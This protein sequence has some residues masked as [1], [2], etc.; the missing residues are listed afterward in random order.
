MLRNFARRAHRD[1]QIRQAREQ[2][3]SPQAESAL[4][5]ASGPPSA[6]TLL[7]AA[8]LQRLLA[9]L[10]LALDE[11]Y[12]STILV[13]FYQGIEPAEIARTSGVPAGTVRWRVSEGIRRLRAA[14][15]SRPDTRDWR[16]ALLPF[17]PG[18]GAGAPVTSALKG[19]LMIMSTK[20]KLGVVTFAVAALAIGAWTWSA[21][22]IGTRS[23]AG[24]GGS[25]E[26][27]PGQGTPGPGST[28]AETQAVAT[29]S[30]VPPPAGGQRPGALA[31][32]RPTRR[33]PPRLMA[34]AA[35]TA[36]APDPAPAERRGTLDKDE[37]R[38]AMRQVIPALKQCYAKLLE[39]QPQTSGRLM[40]QITI[41]ENGSGG[42]RISE[43]SVVPQSTDDGT[44]ELIAPLAEQCMLNAIAEAPFPAPQG[45]PVVVRYP[46]SFAPSGDMV[47]GTA[48]AP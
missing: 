12:R 22:P 25:P 39:Q 11:P 33:P 4:A 24:P 19:G 35:G 43:A 32:A 28:I 38:K 23:A 37:I 29:S 30:P 17:V 41:T 27:L 45:G 7:E 21:L 40:F 18:L 9:D 3:N 1:R 34:V 47:P 15:D 13:R 16:R 6:E 26:S 5:S 10:V 14:L 46:F 36:P 8:Q 44:P 48:R 42:G 20:A 2:S 31:R